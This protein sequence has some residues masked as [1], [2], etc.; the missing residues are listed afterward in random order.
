MK[1]RLSK[2][3]AFLMMAVAIRGYSQTD[4]FSRAETTVP[5]LSG[6]T[7]SECVKVL[8]FKTEYQISLELREYDPQAQYRLDLVG[9][10]NL[11]IGTVLSNLLSQT[12]DYVFVKANGSVN[13]IPRRGP[14]DTQSVFDSVLTGYEVKAQ[15]LVGAFEP[16]CQKRP[17]IA[18]VFPVIVAIDSKPHWIADQKADTRAGPSFSLTLHDTTVRGVINEIAR[19]SEDS[20]W[21]AQ[22]SPEVPPKWQWVSVF[23]RDY[24]KYVLWEHD[25]G[26]HKQ[27][28]QITR[29]QAQEY[30]KTHP[31]K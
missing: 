24:G 13:V 27:F 1:T 16:L 22:P 15:N 26:L 5:E 19:K 23:R 30:E 11:P 25:P 28:E 12:G 7:I 31:A 18:L 4:A 20:F 6:L 8:N 10:R 2:A 29:E 21:I 14:G 3:L 17:Q 9:L